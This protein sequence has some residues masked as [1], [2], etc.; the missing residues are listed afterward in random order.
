MIEFNIPEASY[1]LVS[2]WEYSVLILHPFGSTIGFNNS[3]S[4]LTESCSC[5]QYSKKEEDIALVIV[6]FDVRSLFST[7]NMN[8]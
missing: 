6:D 2:M 5:W 1:L 4:T 3:D 8:T 7:V